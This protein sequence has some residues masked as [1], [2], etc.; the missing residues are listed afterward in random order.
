MFTVIYILNQTAVDPPYCAKNHGSERMN[1][2]KE[3]QGK[4]KIQK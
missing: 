1:E 4:I 2:N 3:G